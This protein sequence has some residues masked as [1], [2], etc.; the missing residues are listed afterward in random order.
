[1]M[2]AD[3]RDGLGAEITT[4][5]ETMEWAGRTERMANTMPPACEKCGGSQ[6]FVGK[7][8]AIRLLPLLEVYKCSPCNQV[9]AMRP[10]GRCQA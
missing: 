9:V 6:A 1:M 5:G 3:T 8:P 2:P 7:L 4:Q 10:G